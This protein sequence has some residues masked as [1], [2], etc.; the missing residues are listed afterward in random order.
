VK[1]VLKVCGVILILL[2]IVGTIN[3]GWKASKP[4]ADP[5]RFVRI[6]KQRVF[7]PTDTPRN[8]FA[9]TSALM[10]QM[11]YMPWYRA[12]VIGQARRLLTPAKI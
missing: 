1:L 4:Q 9:E 8:I 5:Q 12:C 10:G 6:G 3:G 11:G 7:I 2:V